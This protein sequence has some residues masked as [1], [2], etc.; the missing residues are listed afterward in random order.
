MMKNWMSF[1][2]NV[3]GLLNGEEF[4]D[5]GRKK[6]QEIFDT[7]IESKIP[8]ETDGDE[9]GCYL[10]TEGELSISFFAGCDYMDE[11]SI[12]SSL[13]RMTIFVE[14][15]DVSIEEAI[16]YA[17]THTISKMP[18]AIL[19]TSILTTAGEYVLEDISLEKA[20]ELVGNN[21]LDSAVGHASTAEIMTTLLR[22]EIPVNRQMFAQ[23]VGQQALVFKLNGRPQEGKILT[24]DEIEEIGYKFQL[25][26]RKK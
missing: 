2:V 14:G 16:D 23:Q 6:K 26:T 25:L 1:L 17:K 9:D 21:D 24:V 18:L 5:L 12:R 10:F 4:E 22:A 19:N 7:F 8:Y 13:C 3:K 11:A 15:N 20:K